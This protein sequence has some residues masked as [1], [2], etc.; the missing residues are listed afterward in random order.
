MHIDTTHM[1]HLAT[2]KLVKQIP[3]AALSLNTAPISQIVV[4]T[5][6]FDT[7]IWENRISVVKS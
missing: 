7:K 4:S 1:P 2:L 6:H 3:A 5:R